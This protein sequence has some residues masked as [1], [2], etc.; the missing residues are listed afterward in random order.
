VV[1][2]VVVAVTFVVI[3]IVIV[4][5]I[6][7]VGTED[8]YY[9]D[10]ELCIF[11]TDFVA[12]VAVVAVVMRKIVSS[13]ALFPGQLVLKFFLLRIDEMTS[14]R[15]S[16]VGAIELHIEIGVVPIRFEFEMALEEHFGS[17]GSLI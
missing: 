5:G 8:V 7:E 13:L 12:V 14:H 10:E 17:V 6:P 11:Q 1:V 9:K 3:V 16:T 2:V 15:K 4:N